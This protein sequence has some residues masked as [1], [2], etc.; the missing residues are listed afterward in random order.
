MATRNL[1]AFDFCDERSSGRPWWFASH[2]MG[3]LNRRIQYDR[4]CAEK[5][6]LLYGYSLLVWPPVVNADLACG[7]A[8]YAGN[9]I[10]IIFLR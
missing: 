2:N 6:F 7:T 3:L 9:A 1:A 5:P 8:T 4:R 10:S